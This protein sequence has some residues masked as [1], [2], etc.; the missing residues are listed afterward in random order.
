MIPLFD[1]L[2]RVFGMSIAPDSG[3]RCQDLAL[4][5]G[6]ELVR[7]PQL[8]GKAAGRAGVG[9]SP[10]PFSVWASRCVA[11]SFSITQTCLLRRKEKQEALGFVT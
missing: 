10:R 5:E 6:E 8:R 4:G 2:I 7:P 3:V 11:E 1:D 9:S